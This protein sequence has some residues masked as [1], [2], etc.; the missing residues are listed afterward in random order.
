[1]LTG[2]MGVLIGLA[3]IT[4]AKVMGKY[5]KKQQEKREDTLDDNL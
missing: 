5:T 2:L 1:M 4:F 3:A